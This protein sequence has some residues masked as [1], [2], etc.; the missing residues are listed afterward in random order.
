MAETYYT[1]YSGG[2]PLT[3][4]NCVPNIK[5][6]QLKQKQVEGLEEELKGLK[7]CIA[8]LSRTCQALYNKN[9]RLEDYIERMSSCKTISALQPDGVYGPDL[10]SHTPLYSDPDQV[11]LEDVMYELDTVQHL[12]NVKVDHD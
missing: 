3:S 1:N 5:E 2:M 10:G 4:I 9:Q 7:T 8:A 12:G 11:F 6:P